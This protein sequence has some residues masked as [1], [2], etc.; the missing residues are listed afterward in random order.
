MNQIQRESPVQVHFII[1]FDWKMMA[2]ICSAILIR[3]Q[4]K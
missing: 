3:L 2:V 4:L 1:I